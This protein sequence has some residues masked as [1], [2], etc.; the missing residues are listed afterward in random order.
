MLISKKIRPIYPLQVSCIFD[1][2]LYTCP[3]FFFLAI[4][5]FRPASWS[6]HE[7]RWFC[8]KQLAVCLVVLV[9][10]QFIVP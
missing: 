3:F 7:G 4:Y 5:M 10:V 6:I 8:I 9:D 1:D 2:T